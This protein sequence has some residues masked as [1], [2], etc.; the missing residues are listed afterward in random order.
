MTEDYGDSSECEDEYS[1]DKNTIYSMYKIIPKK[2]DLS[3]CY[4]GHTNNFLERKRQHIKCSTDI[5]DPKHHHLVYQ[6]IYKNGGWDEWEMIEIEKYS[7]S[8][9]LEA[10]MREQQLIIQYNANINTL[11]AFIT[12]DERKKKKQEITKK[13]KAEHVELIKE[14]QQQY[15]QEHKEVIKEQMR[16]YRQEHKAEIYEKKKQYMEA[17]KEHLQAKK[18]A[19]TE[20]NKERLKANRKINDAKKKAK[21]L[22]E[23]E[24]ITLI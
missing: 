18:K 3:Y 17:N 13:Y 4:I 23:K 22:E 12:E 19:W 5:N 8:T 11:R 1:D 16:K 20:A 10:R 14:Q 15:K 24:S 21:L 9:K 6:T 2:S 7:C